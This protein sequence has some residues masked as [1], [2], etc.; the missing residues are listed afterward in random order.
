VWREWNIYE[1]ARAKDYLG[2]RDPGVYATMQLIPFVPVYQEARVA[3]DA[4]TYSKVQ[5]DRELELAMYPFAYGEVFG[6][7]IEEAAFLIPGLSG[8]PLLVSPA[9]WGSGFATGIGLGT[10]KAGV[11]ARLSGFAHPDLQ[12]ETE[13]LRE[14]QSMAPPSTSD[15][16]DG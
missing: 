4:I 3:S 8:V 2:V 11:D 12:N 6:V 1:A 10:A 13:G 7:T 9:I 15:E 5:G 16:S 14:I